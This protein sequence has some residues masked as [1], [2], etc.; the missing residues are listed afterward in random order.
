MFRQ[1]SRAATGV[2]ILK[3]RRLK[4]PKCEIKGGLLFDEDYLGFCDN[5]KINFALCAGESWVR[6]RGQN[7]E[8]E[9]CYI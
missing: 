4:H 9:V 8:E 5:H 2:S 1:C 6:R 7:G 3:A